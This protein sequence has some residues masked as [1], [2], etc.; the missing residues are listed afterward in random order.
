MI[1]E[2]I[3]FFSR[4]ADLCKN[5]ILVLYGGQALES[6]LSS[7]HVLIVSHVKYAVSAFRALLMAS[8]GLELAAFIASSRSVGLFYDWVSSSSRITRKLGSSIFQGRFQGCL[9]LKLTLSAL[10]RR[11]SQTAYCFWYISLPPHASTS[12]EWDLVADQF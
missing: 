5:N 6:F 10:T 3:C 8:R 2:N 1:I 4:E 11:N 7:L 9:L 12:K